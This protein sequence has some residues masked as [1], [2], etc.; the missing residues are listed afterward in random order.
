M[1]KPYKEWTIIPEDSTEKIKPKTKAKTKAKAKPKPKVKALA[2]STANARKLAIMHHLAYH[3]STS[4]LTVDILVANTKRAAPN[5]RAL[6]QELVR[7]IRDAVHGAARIKRKFS[8]LSAISMKNVRG[9]EDG[10]TEEDDEEM[11]RIIGTLGSSAQT[12]INLR[13]AFPN[14]VCYN[15]PSIAGYNTPAIFTGSPQ[16]NNSS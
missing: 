5:S 13:G 2:T 14:C 10:E 11:M 15:T 7:C 1:F 6:Q 12:Y 9:Q 8:G 3:H 16:Q 4:T